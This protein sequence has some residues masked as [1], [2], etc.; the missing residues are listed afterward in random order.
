LFDTSE[1]ITL[2]PLYFF[3]EQLD[4][5]LNLEGIMLKNND[6]N[7]NIIIDLILNFL[8]I[9]NYFIYNDDVYSK[10]ENTLISYEKIDS[11]KEIFFN[12]F[13]VNVVSFFTEYFPCQFDGFDFYYLIKTFKNKMEWCIDKI[14][15]LTTNK[16]KL[17]F[18]FLEF[19][20]GIYDIENNNFIHSN[21]FI[22]VLHI[23]TIKY[24]NK[25]YS[26]VRQAKPKT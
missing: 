2:Y 5:Y 23:C 24:Y 15:N 17:N 22:N 16:I 20:D 8:K 1:A 26:S 18:S 6:I 19:T 12:K 10:I 3:N 14:K 13:E 25:S 9:K 4:M 11:V 21:D 7:E